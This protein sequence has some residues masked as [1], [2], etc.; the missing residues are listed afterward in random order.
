MAE[1]KP[2]KYSEIAEPNLL[3]PLRKEL[4]K[5]DK[6]LEN[7]SKGL[8]DMITAAAELSKSAPLT[9]WE[10]IGEVETSIDGAT[11]AVREL[12]KV[13][14]ERV[15]LQV[16]I[17]E[18][19]DSRIKAN[20]QLKEQIRVQTK[21]LRDGAKAT[22]TAGD[23]YEELKRSTNK[24]QLELKKIASEFGA[25]S[26]QAKKSAKQ[27]NILDDRLRSVNKVAKDGRRDVGR[28][29]LAMSK[30]T[31]VFKKLAAA[32]VVL[33]IFQLLT[34]SLRGNTELVASL[35][36]KWVIVTGAIQ[37]YANLISDIYK[38]LT[39]NF[40]LYVKRTQLGLAQLEKGFYGALDFLSAGKTG[41]SGFEEATKDVKKLSEE[42]SVLEKNETSISG[43]FTNLGPDVL[44]IIKKQRNL[45]D[46]TIKYNREITKL[47]KEKIKL[48]AVEKALYAAFDDDTISLQNQVT[49]GKE[50][51][52]IKRQL[53]ELSEREGL[54][55]KDLA[56]QKAAAFTKDD[57]LQR[58][59]VN[60]EIEYQQ[61]IGQN[62]L[63]LRG[64]Q[65]KQ[66]KASQDLI[67][68]NLDVIIDSVAKQRALN[69]ESIKDETL[70]YEKR[71]SL[72]EVNKIL[73]QDSLKNQ[74]DSINGIVAIRKQ[75][76][77][78]SIKESKLSEKE[79]S[80]QIKELE[81]VNFDIEDISNLGSTKKI[82]EA[83]RQVNV[84][85]Q[86]AIRVREILEDHSSGLRALNN[87]RRALN[88]SIAEGNYIQTD[89]VLVEEAVLNIRKKRSD[90]EKV[91][92]N[93]ED[94]RRQNEKKN[95]EE[96]LK[97]AKKG[98]EL[99]IEIEK[100]L[101]GK[102]LEIET[103]K[104]EEL[105]AIETA[106][107]EKLAKQQKKYLEA[108]SAGFEL[109]GEIATNYSAKR[110]AEIDEEI[111]AEKNRIQTLEV[112]AG[113]GN[114]DAKNNLALT[115]KRQSELE[116]DR[117]KQIKRQQLTELTLTALQIYSNKL[118]EDPGNALVSTISD[119]QVLR[120]FVNSLPG[121]Y[122]GTENTGVTG[123]IK[124]NN[125]FITGF[126]H[127]N[128]RVI[129]ANQNK[130]IGN[131]TNLELTNLAVGKNT[132]TDTIS[133]EKIYTI[134]NEIK[135]VTKEKPV[136]LGIDYNEINKSIITTIKK[137]QKTNRIHKKVGGIW[138]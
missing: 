131:L 50:Y 63:D 13:E 68:F 89:T 112:L 83:I 71:L 30:L 94:D 124:D 2:I 79:K 116:L 129:N 73:Y 106:R 33:K 80:R 138:G 28:Y 100:E 38:A 17:K 107:N 118:N 19:D 75:A 135:Q 24:A 25:T 39:N 16:R 18:L 111:K 43:I 137:G 20:F 96:R 117:D 26:K 54:L 5:L 52:K 120:A 69:S 123:Q 31:R 44:D 91:L 37:G 97:I 60:A 21:S 7:A 88:D 127:E 23:A 53:N 56:I 98:S 6:A 77:I 92:K 32:T 82:L 78:D 114:E 105:L 55:I 134:L 104:S 99:Y 115:E 125:G 85:E 36:K 12:D 62:E 9:T 93:L 95:L 42:I 27:F 58:D 40:F 4:I 132:G 110:I 87:D 103:K 122:E 81:G 101:A 66:V 102:I 130:M 126:T 34:L 3:E 64:A 119:I 29:S 67:E 76:R 47:R 46:D 61:L 72:L 128:E 22:A 41:T 59:A 136:Y 35:E 113:Q 84:S 65:Q 48:V 70:T 1:G 121:F 8:M 57:S 90:T 49:A 108:A 11:K 45:I 15:K 86:I 133:Y 109:L 14:K 74:Q 51:I 10:N